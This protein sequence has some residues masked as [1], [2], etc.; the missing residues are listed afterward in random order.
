MEEKLFDTI[1]E[2]ISNYQYTSMRYI[3]YGEVCNYDIVSNTEQLVLLCGYYDPAKAFEYHWAA[4]KAEDIIAL[5]D[6]KE[7]L[8]T[9][10]PQEWIKTFEGAGFYIRSAWHDHFK[11]SLSDIV[12]EVK[13]AIVLKDSECK[14]A[15]EVTMSCRYKSRG[16]TGETEEFF[17]E[18]LS[19][20]DKDHPNSIIFV[21]KN[22]I[23]EI[24][25]LVCTTTY[26]HG[27]E[28][29]PVAWIREVCV[30]PEYQNRGIAR[31]LILQAL[32]HGKKHGA[33]RA[34]L[35]ADEMNENAIHLYTSIGFEPSKEES[36]IDMIKYE[37][38]LV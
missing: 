8:I 10:V 6:K 27:S 32:S 17:R 14:E 35:A 2:S 23:G 21:E 1:Q 31:K 7:S 16:F 22:D 12:D 24:V 25:G 15:S 29:G 20:N 38:V 34:F 33:T 3:D 13:D 19:D 4:N 30:R 5:I 18:W 26:G 37:E 9:F 28:K 11:S 36:Q